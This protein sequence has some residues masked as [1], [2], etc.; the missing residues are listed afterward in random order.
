M[1]DTRD[2][3][4]G[5]SDEPAR[6]SPSDGPT[7]ATPDGVTDGVTVPATDQPDA[8]QTDAV[9]ARVRA[10][11]PAAA[12]TPDTDR[13]HARLADAT[14]VTLG[15]GEGPADDL[16]AA[17]ARRR[18]AAR[19]LQVAAVAAGVALVGGGGYA[20]GAAGADEPS[21]P[22][23]ALQ[24]AGGA[25][26]TAGASDMSGA[27]VRSK[28][29]GPGWFGG[30]TVFSGSGLTGAAGSARAWAFDATS[31]ATAA[32]AAHVAN[33]LGVAG[34]PRQEWGQ[35]V[36][37][38]N[39]G[40][41]AT[42]QVGVDGQASM[43]FYDRAWDPSVCT[44]GVPETLDGA[45]S[46][47]AAEGSA[48]EPDVAPRDAAEPGV[49]VEPLPAPD[50]PP[51]PAPADPSVC[52]PAS[53]PTGDAAAARARDLMTR[54]G[55]DPGGYEV[56]VS[57]ETGVPGLVSVTGAQ[58][59][60][61]TQTG[62]GWSVQLVGTGVQ[63]VSGPLATLV[64]LGTYDHVSADDAVERLNDPRFGASFGGMVPLAARAEGAVADDSVSM[65]AEPADE[66]TVPAVP[67]PGDP[68]AW[69]V[70]QVTI[71]GARLGVTLLTTPTGAT[72]LVPAWELTDAD[73]STWSVVAV[74]EDQ[75][76]LSAA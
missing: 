11:D 7:D 64:E 24:G 71:T 54:L 32:T 55:V 43:W 1:D 58:V 63:S 68:V 15:A 26:E 22:P 35:W 12:T 27:D 60:D 5:T 39:D 34:E 6:H 67:A 17:R 74:V 20:V 21:A 37:G 9:V 38:A 76:D 47:G 19:W 50:V 10:A 51:E 33:V 49:A 69:P 72:L 48:V 70:Q 62:L 57:D 31:A 18:P 23:I 36:V 73:G 65:Q 14:G 30:R 56:T 53:T 61:G 75:L 2:P 25:P 44:S 52:D 66:P 40:L 28:M 8:A 3:R 45:T 29:V 16:A 42:V 4:D 59:V 41:S 46:S 13:L